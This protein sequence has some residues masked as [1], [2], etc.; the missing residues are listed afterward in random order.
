MDIARV[1]LPTTTK[2]KVHHKWQLVNENRF[3]RKHF[4]L[5]ITATAEGGGG[6]PPTLFIGKTITPEARKRSKQNEKHQSG[7]TKKDGTRTEARCGEEELEV[8]RMKS[9]NVAPQKK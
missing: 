4:S 6:V 7:E 9:S 3:S 2:W 5:F 1:K 8:N